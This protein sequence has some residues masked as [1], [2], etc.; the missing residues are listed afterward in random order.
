MTEEIK[1]I[2]GNGDDLIQA[3]EEKVATNPEG[4]LAKIKVGDVEYKVVN[5]VTMIEIMVHKLENG[6]EVS[7]VVAHEFMMVDHKTYMIRLL[8]DA[9][10]TVARAKKRTNYIKL[11]SEVLFNKLRN[12]SKLSSFL[13]SKH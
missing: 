7:Q 6:Q 5:S 9:I 12:R 8:T 13:R 3:P 2:G 10:N 4:H 1:K 11:A